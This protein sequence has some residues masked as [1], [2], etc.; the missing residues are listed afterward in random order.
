M[1]N[2]SIIGR[3]KSKLTEVELVD[4]AVKRYLDKREAKELERIAREK[5]QKP[6]KEIVFTIEWKRSQMWGHNP[7]LECAVSYKDGSFERFGPFKASGC[8]YD[9]ESTVIAEAFNKLLKYKLWAMPVKKRLGGNGSTDRANGKAPY[10]V[11]DYSENK[12]R[13]HFGG[14]I[15]TD[16]YYAIAT[17]IGGKFERVS[18]GKSFDV[19]KYTG[20]D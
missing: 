8:G 9:K 11:L 18:S 10:G 17:F 6:I 4:R 13:P 12:T 1:E 7:S 5:S 3:P 2:K 15:G 19:Y 14:G 20:L 16:C